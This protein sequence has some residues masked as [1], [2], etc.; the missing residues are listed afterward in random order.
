MQLLDFHTLL[1]GVQGGEQRRA[2][3]P[4]LSGKNWQDCSSDRYFQELETKVQSLRFLF[5]HLERL[6]SFTVMTSSGLAKAS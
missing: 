2:S 1:K 3:T 6:K 4:I 5:G